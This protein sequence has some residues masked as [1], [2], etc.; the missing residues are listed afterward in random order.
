[1][2]TSARIAIVT[3]ASRGLGRSTVLS[4]AKRGV[5]SIFTYNSHRLERPWSF[6]CSCGRP[7]LPEGQSYAAARLRL[8]ASMR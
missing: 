5:Q 4:L 8:R 6:S 2:T 1:M 3:G 7:L